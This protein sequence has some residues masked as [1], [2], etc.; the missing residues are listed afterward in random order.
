MTAGDVFSALSDPTRRAVIRFLSERGPSSA[1]E[2]AASMPVTR[3]AVA[4]HLAALAD[5]GLVES[6]ARGRERRYRLTPAPL[7]RAVSWMASVGAEWDERLEDL[8]RHL[9]GGQPPHR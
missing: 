1:T 8:R 4:K 6:E 5:A 3:Q 9:G 7:E 2:V